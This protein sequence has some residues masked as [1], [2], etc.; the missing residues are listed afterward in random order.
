MQLV[1]KEELRCTDIVEEM[2]VNFVKYY[3]KCIKS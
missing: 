3:I 1:A 2:F